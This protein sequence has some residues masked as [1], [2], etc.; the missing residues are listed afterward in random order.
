MSFEPLVATAALFALATVL[1]VV[2][3]RRLIEIHEAR[4][5][6]RR[7]SVG[8]IRTVSG[9]TIIVFWLMATWFFATILGDWAHTGDF[10]G[11]VDRSWLRLRVLL[12][13]AAA[14]ADS[15]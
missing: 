11:A 3:V 9:W 4:H 1:G 2:P 14:L 6:L 15:D 8:F 5:E 12:E 7:G 13:I 10:Q